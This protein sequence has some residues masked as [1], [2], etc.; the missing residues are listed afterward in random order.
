MSEPKLVVL[1]GYTLNPGDNPW[2][3]VAEHGDL[4]VWEETPKDQI[5]ERARDADIVLTN[6]TPLTAETIAELPRLKFVSVL[7][8]GYNVV[9]LDAARE[10]DVVVSN[11]PE[12]ATDSVAQHVF[13]LLLELTNRVCIHDEAIREGAWPEATGFCFWRTPLTELAGKTLGVVGYG[14]IGRRVGEIGAA[15]GMKVVAHSPSGTP[16]EPAEPLGTWVELDALFT[17]SDVISLNCAL[18]EENRGMVDADRFR[19]MKP[20]AFLINTARGALVDNDALGHAVRTGEIA[21]AGL[22]VV[23][24][25]PIGGEHPVLD[26]PNVLVTPHN[27]WTSIESRRRLT[28]ITADN[29]EAFLSGD[30]VHVVS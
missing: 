7:A 23:E 9:D 26:L 21:G 10:H 14:R 1:D 11:V 6:K 30:P 28:A 17:E 15:F 4:T 22:D 3:P 5:V 24:G 12:Y 19:Q 16:G 8:T 27:A 13:A 25:E 20:T 29:I 18:T 2:D